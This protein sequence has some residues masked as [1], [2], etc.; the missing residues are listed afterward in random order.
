[1][2]FLPL[3]IKHVTLNNAAEFLER[4]PQDIVLPIR[5]HFLALEVGDCLKVGVGEGPGSEAFWLEIVSI[6]LPMMV[7][8]IVNHLKF[9]EVHGL[10]ALDLILVNPEHVIAIHID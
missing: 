9:T 7:G 3:D 5:E 8:K 4:H 1:M 6:G 2:P 10:A